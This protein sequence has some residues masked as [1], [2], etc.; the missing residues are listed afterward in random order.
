MYS[1]NLNLAMLDDLWAWAILAACQI[2]ILVWTELEARVELRGGNTF[3]VRIG[4][5][6][7]HSIPIELE[8]GSLLAKADNVVGGVMG[9]ACV[10]SLLASC[11]LVF[12]EAT[13]YEIN[14]LGRIGWTVFWVE[15]YAADIWLCLRWARHR[16]R[17]RH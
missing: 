16:H 6:P 2:L 9:L 14:L 7:E 3:Y 5:S 11:A 4:G 12:P 1:R 13:F 8:D 10:P 15:L 17:R